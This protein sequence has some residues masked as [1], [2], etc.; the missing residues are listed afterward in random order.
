MV[1]NNL[2]V[3]VAQCWSSNVF[4]GQNQILN[5]QMVVWLLARNFLSKTVCCW[6]DDQL[7]QAA[8]H[9]VEIWIKNMCCIKVNSSEQFALLEE[10]IFHVNKTYIFMPIL[11]SY[12]GKLFVV[13][14]FS[15]ES[16][17][18]KRQ[19]SSSVICSKLAIF[20]NCVF[21]FLSNAWNFV[22]SCW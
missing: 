18:T 3:L 2:M 6:A 5:D 22:W 12:F 9:H 19:L 17:K 16:S 10:I 13:G 1:S 7:K 8:A 4:L 20:K 11:C 21:S 14:D 15:Q